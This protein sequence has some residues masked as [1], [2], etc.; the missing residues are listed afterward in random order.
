MCGNTEI[1]GQALCLALDNFPFQDTHEAAY[2]RLRSVFSLIREAIFRPRF[3]MSS[4]S[5]ALQNTCSIGEL[6]SMYNT[7]RATVRHDKIIALLGMASQDDFSNLKNHGLLPDYRV[8]WQELLRRLVQFILG[9]KVRIET[10][11]NEEKAEIFGKG[12]FMGIVSSLFKDSSGSVAA[13]IAEF[14]PVRTKKPPKVSS[15]P[16]P[17]SANEVRVGD[18][19]WI[20]EG[21]AHP[22]II[23][24]IEMFFYI[25][26]IEV[27]STRGWESRINPRN[28]AT[29]WDWAD[30]P[31]ES[32]SP[33]SMEAI[34]RWTTILILQYLNPI[35][36]DIDIGIEL[37]EMDHVLDE[38]DSSRPLCAPDSI[39][40]TELIELIYMCNERA[41]YQLLCWMKS[42]GKSHDP[43]QVGESVILAIAKRHGRS[44]LEKVLQLHHNPASTDVPS[45]CSTNTEDIVSDD[46]VQKHGDD[47]STGLH[48]ETTE[49]VLVAAV[50]ARCS[51]RTINQLAK[52]VAVTDASLVAGLESYYTTGQMLLLLNYAKPNPITEAVLVAAV[53]FAWTD[54]DCPRMEMLLN[55]PSETRHQITETILL[56]AVENWNQGPPIL[57]MLLVDR[58]AELEFPN[59][60]VT[61]KLLEA[62]VQD[63]WHSLRAVAMLLSL[64]VDGAHITKAVVTEAMNN[65]PRRHELIPLL[66]RH[67]GRARDI[68]LSVI[69]DRKDDTQFGFWSDLAEAPAPYIF[70]SNG[71][72]AH[73]RDKTRGDG[74][75]GRT[76]SKFE[77]KSE[78]VER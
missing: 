2:H 61:S 68:Y 7:R 59:G 50:R 54:S 3:D 35:K 62:A 27:P 36:Q 38:K 16:L 39:I 13:Q 67:S 78:S 45:L 77:S 52:S 76:V 60:K 29:I 4:N 63:R 30:M 31:K 53:Q 14:E 22:M 65:E 28:I 10:R 72:S 6:M 41:M 58:A 23:R 18:L 15:L 75:R 73:D 71:D 21:S 48:V 25:I 56:A 1:D 64:D 17:A 5:K 34:N 74:E 20:F 44:L 24:R 66:C 70:V 37:M 49:A 43:I 11:A 46:P 47:R 69:A 32:F 26:M 42:K 57:E 9:S 19:V 12:Y 40:E 8:S 33:G 51:T 55:M